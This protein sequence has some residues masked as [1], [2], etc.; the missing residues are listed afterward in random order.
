MYL[1]FNS[2]RNYMTQ[3]QRCRS[4]A[5]LSVSKACQGFSY[6]LIM[7]QKKTVINYLRLVFNYMVLCYN[8]SILTIP[9]YCPCKINEDKYLYEAVLKD[10]PT[11]DTL[12]VI[13]GTKQSADFCGEGARQMYGYLYVQTA[14]SDKR[15]S[16]QYI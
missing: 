5:G 14:M 6:L 7:E 8:Y 13:F 15:Q 9:Y 4:R 10:L 2:S 12:S 1:V 3:S 16:I 11:G